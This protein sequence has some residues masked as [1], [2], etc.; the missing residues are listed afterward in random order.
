MLIKRCF[1]D[2]LTFKTGNFRQGVLRKK[3]YFSSSN[4]RLYLRNMYRSLSKMDILTTILI[5]GYA[6]IFYQK[7]GFCPV[8]ATWICQYKTFITGH[9]SYLFLEFLMCSLM[10][11]FRTCW[12]SQW[13]TGLSQLT[14][15]LS[16]RTALLSQSAAWLSQRAA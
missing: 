7:E 15:G 9:G 4:K 8:F 13:A 14:D 5:I 11:G 6:V 12:L 1:H 3:K 16:Q 10:E 2:S